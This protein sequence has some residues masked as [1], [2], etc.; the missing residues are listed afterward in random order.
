MADTCQR[1]VLAIAIST[2]IRERRNVASHPG[3]IILATFL[4]PVGIA[5]DDFARVVG[6][7]RATVAAILA[8]TA[9]F[10]VGIAVRFARALGLPAERIVKMQTAHDFARARADVSLDDVVPMPLPPGIAFDDAT[11]IAGRLGCA[12]VDADGE[13]YFFQQD[14]EGGEVDPYAGLHALWR[15]DA[16]RV[17]EP[18]GPIVW[19]GPVM[20]N[21]D[22]R[23]LLPFVRPSDW[24]PWFTRS[25]P[26]HLIFGADHLAFIEKM[27]A[28]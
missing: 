15:G 6:L 19:T 22:G 8:G 25:L 23:M 17:F 9:G 1:R 10:D 13:S 16:L 3:P 12:G 27:H 20:Q 28:Q 14:F 7:E 11:A 26:A 18:T 21:L 24:R 4:E 5:I 2:V